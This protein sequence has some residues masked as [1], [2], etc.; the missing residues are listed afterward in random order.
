MM[1]KTLAALMFDSSLDPRAEGTA[2]QCGRSAIVIDAKALY[3]ALQKDGIGSGADKR[4]SIDI[5]C[6]KE[7]ISRLHC[8]LRWVS[9]ERMLADGLTKLHTRQNFVVMLG[10]GCLKLVNDETFTAAKKKDKHTRAASTASTFGRN[11]VA[12]RIAMVVMAQS[13]TSAEAA[14]REGDDDWLFSVFLAVAVAN[15]FV[16]LLFGWNTLRRHVMPWLRGIFHE[17]HGS[18][19][20]TGV[21]TEVCLQALGPVLEEAEL[22]RSALDQLSAEAE[23]RDA[24][25]VQRIHELQE[26]ISHLSR[27]RAQSTLTENLAAYYTAHGSCWHAFRDCHT[28]QRSPR[29]FEKGHLCRICIDRA[30]GL[31]RARGR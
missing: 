7:E 4:A 8:E 30:R 6:I 10:S 9:S 27:D 25:R 2:A 12:E 18:V 13:I 5:L 20:N 29:V 28:L 31:D 26:E 24:S 17:A 3:D 11:R 22:L 19:V 1:M 15:F 21:Q 16:L 23:Q 14:G